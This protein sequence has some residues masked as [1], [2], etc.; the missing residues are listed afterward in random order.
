MKIKNQIS[1]IKNATASGFTLIEMLV[2]IAIIAIVS[3][4][5]IVGINPAKRIQDAQ[6]S[7]ARQDVRSTASAVEACL[8]YADI[9]S[10]KT[11]TPRG[12]SYTSGGVY[13]IALTSPASCTPSDTQIC[14]APFARAVPTV[15]ISSDGTYVCVS[16]PGGGTPAATWYYSSATG[17]VDSTK[18]AGCP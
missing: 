3:G 13:S 5:V 7:K 10:G 16:E 14:G 9:V 6:D 11:N 1:S 2:T 12:C 17:K 15:A 18:P 4:V 8:S